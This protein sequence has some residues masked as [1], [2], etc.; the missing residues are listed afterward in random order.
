MLT[1]TIRR[2]L[3]WIKLVRRSIR[4]AI[5]S[6]V[7]GTGVTVVS[8]YFYNPLAGRTVDFIQNGIPIT[9]MTHIAGSHAQ[10]IL[11]S[12]LFVD[13]VF[14]TVVFHSILYV[15]TIR[16]RNIGQVQSKPLV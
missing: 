8:G 11:W 9:W 1:L 3:R 6:T 5:V 7:L 12:Q 4:G 14:W 2:T 15:T 16:Q 13:V 10:N